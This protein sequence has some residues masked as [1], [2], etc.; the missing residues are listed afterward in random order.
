M[1]IENP[2]GGE[3]NDVSALLTDPKV[4]ELYELYQTLDDAMLESIIYS[5]PDASERMISL[6]TLVLG[7]RKKER[8][9]Y[10]PDD[11]NY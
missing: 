8:G 6:A 11:G 1:G 5:M 10:P 9:D 3:E 2:Q 7:E 4:R